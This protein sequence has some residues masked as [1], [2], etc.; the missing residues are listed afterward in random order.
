MDTF[1]F[2]ASFSF[3]ELDHVFNDDN[4]KM[5]AAVRYRLHIDLHVPDTEWERQPE[6][7]CLVSVNL[8]TSLTFKNLK[9]FLELLC[10]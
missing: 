1:S 4:A 9:F 3:F 5:I 8:P 2:Y 10:S 6:T 7:L